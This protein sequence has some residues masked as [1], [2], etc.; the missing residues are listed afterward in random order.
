MTLYIQTSIRNVC[1]YH[2]HAYH[3]HHHHHHH[4]FLTFVFSALFLIEPTI[5]IRKMMHEYLSPASSPK[6]SRKI[7]VR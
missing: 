3:H 6:S 5:G 2:H 1:A 4:I 7:H